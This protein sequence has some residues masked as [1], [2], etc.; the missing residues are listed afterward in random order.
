MLGLVEDIAEDKE[1]SVGTAA[2]MMESLAFVPALH[3]CFVVAAANY[4][5]A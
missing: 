2:D 4:Q 3:N 1:N 5:D